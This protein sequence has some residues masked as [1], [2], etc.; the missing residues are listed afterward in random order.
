MHV[1]RLAARALPALAAP[2]LLAGA[3]A[4]IAPAGALASACVAW[5]GTQPPNP[6]SSN[7]LSSVTALSPC[8]AWAVGAAGNRTLIEHWNGTAWKQVASPSTSFPS[9]L[10]S[11]SAVS[12]R[13]AW[14]AGF[15][16]NQTLL[17]PW[18]GNAWKRVATRRLA[19]ATS[20]LNA[21]TATSARSAWA[22]GY[23]VNRSGKQQTLVFHWNGTAWK[24]MASPDPS[25]P[26]HF[27]T[28]N[29]V[30]ATSAT[31]IWAVGFYSTGTGSLA[32][33]LHCC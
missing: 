23:H 25:G 31:N 6:G 13:N 16:A 14:A 19:A 30:T 24:H 10:L 33:A 2:L 15:T 27:N 12:P 29:A 9:A 26:S 18:N 3:L 21:V 28:L 7:V 11:V 1:P 20:L 8:S 17:E 5:T 4:G 32:L 22:V